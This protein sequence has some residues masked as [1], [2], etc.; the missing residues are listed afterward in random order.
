MPDSLFSNFLKEEKVLLIRY[1]VIVY[2][3]NRQRSQPHCQYMDLD[4]STH[5]HTHTHTERRIYIYIYIIYMYNMICI[6]GQCLVGNCEKLLHR[7]RPPLYI[8]SSM[9]R[10]I[11]KTLPGR[12]S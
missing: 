12:F 5:T 3:T 8:I 4:N 10:D 7:R 9:S 6:S 1:I 11:L 2:E